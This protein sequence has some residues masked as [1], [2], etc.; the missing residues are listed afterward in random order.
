MHVPIIARLIAYQ[1]NH[2]FEAIRQLP[3]ARRESFVH[4]Q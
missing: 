4:E 2:Y 1:Q 3:E